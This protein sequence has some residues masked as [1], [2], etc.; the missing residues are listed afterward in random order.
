VKTM[1]YNSRDQLINHCIEIFQYKTYL[2]IGV[3]HS[4]SCFDK[5]NCDKKVGVDPNMGGQHR[6]TSDEY[7]EKYNDKFDIIFIDGLH[8]AEQV[9]KDIENSLNI[10]NDGGTILMHDCNPLQEFRQ[11]KDGAN[12]DCWKACVHYR[13]EPSLDM[14]TVN[15]DQGCGVIRVRKNQSPIKINKTYT[16]LQWDD[17]VEN[18][19]NYLNLVS[20]QQFI[21]WL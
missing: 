6:M 1:L 16:D 20:V 11:F 7:F 9:Y 8:H 17:L 15:I 3:N 12:G 2:E 14:I 13:Q 10:L 21:D 19:Q 4:A 18:R 5:I